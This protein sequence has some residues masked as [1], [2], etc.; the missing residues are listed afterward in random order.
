[1]EFL[2][3]GMK[4]ILS[5]D[6]SLHAIKSIQEVIEKNLPKIENISAEIQNLIS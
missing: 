5:G 4:G 2:D 6:L 1:M 3:K